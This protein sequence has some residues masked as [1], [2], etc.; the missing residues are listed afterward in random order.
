MRPAAPHPPWRPSRSPACRNRASRSFSSASPASAGMVMT[1]WARS[2]CQRSRA[3]S[4][5]SK[6]F[7]YTACSIGR[8]ARSETPT[9]SAASAQSRSAPWAREHS[10]TIG[11]CGQRVRSLVSSRFTAS[12]SARVS[13]IRGFRCP[14]IPIVSGIFFS[15]ICSRPISPALRR[16]VTSVGKCGLRHIFSAAAAGC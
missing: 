5:G 14:V 15:F 16:S 4:F 13:R 10:I 9:S 11:V 3:S 2:S 6:S 8:T 1:D 12:R 7:S